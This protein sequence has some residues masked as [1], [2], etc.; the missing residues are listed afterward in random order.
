MLSP[1]PDMAHLAA[2]DCWLG[3]VLLGAAG[4]GC[5]SE[6]FKRQPD[7]PP[8]ARKSLLFPLLSAHEPASARSMAAAAAMNASEAVLRSLAH[9]NRHLSGQHMSQQLGTTIKGP[10]CCGD[11][12]VSPG[13][14]AWLALH[15]LR[16][17][18]VTGARKAYWLKRLRW[19]KK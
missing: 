2:P 18:K 10:M 19:Y 6:L 5:C 15:R 17:R 13:S 14:S 3:S 4:A 7:S 1:Q 9:E 16:E 8:R 11:R 12:L